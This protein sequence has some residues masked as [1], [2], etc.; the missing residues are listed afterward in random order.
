MPIRSLI[1]DHLGLKIFS[2]ILGTLIWLAVKTNFANPTEADRTF[3]NRPILVLTDSAEHSAVVV[4]PNQASV[5][6]R[7]S[8]SLM[9]LLKDE[10]I[11]VF[12]RLSEK[13]Q[14]TSE[15]PVHVH[16]PAGAAVVLL[17]PA[18]AAVKPAAPN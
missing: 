14:L 2:I 7:G 4:N 9:Q 6:V 3:T 10:D 8:A 13:Q 5:T 1:L 12:V 15:L 17:T 18:T 16:A 11:H